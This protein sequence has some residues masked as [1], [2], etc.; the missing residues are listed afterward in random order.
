[1]LKHRLI[2]ALVLVPVL[3]VMIWFLPMPWF[4]ILAGIIMA[5][6]A[7]EWSGFFEA[8]T[9]LIRIGYVVFIVVMLV[10]TYF[11]PIEWVL[12]VTLLAWIWAA[13]AVIRYQNDEP[14]LGLEKF[15][16]RALLGIFAIVPCWLSINVLREDIG[17]PVWLLFGLILVWVLDIGAYFAGKRWGKKPL[18]SRVSPNKTWEGFYGGVA[19]MFVFAFIIC[20]AFRVPLHRFVMILVLSIIVGLFAV[21]GDLVE[22]LLKRQVGLKDSGKGLPG[23]GGILD[24]IDSVLAALPIFTLG[25]LLMSRFL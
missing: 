15:W 25:S 20:L 13:A 10:V 21:F 14:P 6:A 1:M 4:A 3:I 11:L 23:H 18:M 22:S 12:W 9:L 8:S 24:R 5:W 16:G 17:G 7:W 19:V 2:T